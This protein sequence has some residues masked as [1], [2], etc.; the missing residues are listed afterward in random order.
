MHLSSLG[1]YVLDALLIVWGIWGWKRAFDAE[2]HAEQEANFYKALPEQWLRKKERSAFTTV[3]TLLLMVAMTCP[4]IV[5]LV[6]VR[7]H[8]T[9]PLMCGVVWAASSLS[10]GLAL[11]GNVLSQRKGGQP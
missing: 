7:C 6:A 2:R 9:I 3:G 11:L 5:T 10:I 1:G 8:L 4:A